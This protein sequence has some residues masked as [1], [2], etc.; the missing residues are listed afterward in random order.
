MILWVVRNVKCTNLTSTSDRRNTVKASVSSWGLRR[1]IFL[2][3]TRSLRSHERERERDGQTNSQWAEYIKSLCI[4]DWVMGMLTSHNV[5]I[6]TVCFPLAQWTL[7]MLSSTG[8][9]GIHWL[10]KRMCTTSFNVYITKAPTENTQDNNPFAL[11]DLPCIQSCFTVS[12]HCCRGF[13]LAWDRT[14][15]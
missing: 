14:R 4:N 9:S 10:Q 5:I 12:I 15:S 6:T 11:I 8:T 2:S 1:R 13:T 7:V 3:C